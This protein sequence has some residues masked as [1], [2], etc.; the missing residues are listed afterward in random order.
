MGSSKKCCLNIVYAT[1]ALFRI[2]NKGIYNIDPWIA[3]VKLR[4]LCFCVKERYYR[5]IICSILRGVGAR[6]VIDKSQKEILVNAGS[7]TGSAVVHRKLVVNGYNFRLKGPEEICL[8]KLGLTREPE[9]RR[10]LEVNKDIEFILAKRGAKLLEIGAGVGINTL[11]ILMRFT[12]ISIVTTEVDERCHKILQKLCYDGRAKHIL[13]ESLPPLEDV[14]IALLSSTLIHMREQVLV[15]Q[16]LQEK[17]VPIVVVEKATSHILALL[18]EHKFE[19][20]LILDEK[21]VLAWWI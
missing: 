5:A 1:I 3:R 9:V 21:T 8:Y 17:K 7:Y 19:M 6:E 11:Y 2:R 10:L 20:V 16:K 15:I 18:R 12:N 4:L 13:T 14:T